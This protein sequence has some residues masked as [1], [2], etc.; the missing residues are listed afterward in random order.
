M[1]INNCY[2]SLEIMT[3]QRFRFVTETLQANKKAFQLN[4]KRQLSDSL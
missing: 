2:K 1:N 4:V 3:S